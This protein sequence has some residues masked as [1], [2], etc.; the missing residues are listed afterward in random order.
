MKLLKSAPLLSSI[1]FLRLLTVLGGSKVS[2]E[3]AAQLPS[4]WPMAKGIRAAAYEIECGFHLGPQA[5]VF[6]CLSTYSEQE[7]E[8]AGSKGRLGFCKE[9]QRLG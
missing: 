2:C 7:L 4:F 3:A 1:P 8:T 9:A 5:A 6:P